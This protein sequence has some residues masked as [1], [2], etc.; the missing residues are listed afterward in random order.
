MNGTDARWPKN[1]P[2][3]LPEQQAIRE[4]FMRY[5]HEVLPERY[6]AI[7]RFNHGFPRA[8]RRDW[9]IPR[10]KTLEIGAG[11]GEHIAYEDLS[12]QEYTALELRELMA[13]RI[14]ERYPDVQVL[15][16]DVQERIGVEDA[17]FDRVLAV[18][19]LEHLPNLPAALSEIRRVLKP[20]GRFSAVIPCEGGAMYALGRNLTSRR[21]FEK[22]YQCSYDWFIHTEHI[23]KCWEILDELKKVFRITRSQFWPFRIPVVHANAVLGVDCLPLKSR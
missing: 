20:D 4:D 16:G 6:S 5:W 23:N 13:T 21:L 17:H 18:H 3:L 9:P 1:V 7:E 8:H 12:F 15:V 19:V 22:R 2:A 14:Q 10:I 11:L